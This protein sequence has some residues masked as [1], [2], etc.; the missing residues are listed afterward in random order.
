MGL[1]GGPSEWDE[2]E[3]VR[4]ADLPDTPPPAP[5]TAGGKRQPLAEA[6]LAW[7]QRESVWNAGAGSRVLLVD[8]D[9]LRA[10]PVR[11]RD[12]MGMVVALAR[13]ADV[14]ALAGQEG[15]VRRG[16]P[17]LE[18]FAARARAVADG[19]D[20]ADHVLLDAAA[21]LTGALQFVL[22]SNDWI[23]AGLADRGPLT[24]LSPGAD[25]LSDRLRS[26]AT[27][28]VDLAGLEGSAAEQ[29]RRAAFRATR[30]RTR[31]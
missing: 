4:L 7:L 1:G 18:E 24:V 16:R 10:D 17:H 15:A 8:L 31:V 28:V 20:L 23:F 26:A 25:A 14:V 30:R 5:G 9:N 12:R 2:Y 22:L 21:E 27:K 19:S 13:Q 3:W 11:W 29:G 6:V